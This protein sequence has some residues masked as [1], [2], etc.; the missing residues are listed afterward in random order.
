MIATP[1]RITHTKAPA[2]S[3]AS[4]PPP[5]SSSYPYPSYTSAFNTSTA[6]QGSSSRIRRIWFDS[7]T[8]VSS[9]SYPLE[10]AAAAAAAEAAA[11]AAAED[12]GGKKKPK[13]SKSKPKKGG[14]KGKKKKKGTGGA[15]EED[16][17]PKSG[18]F[19]VDIMPPPPLKQRSDAVGGGGRGDGDDGCNATV[20]RIEFSRLLQQL[21]STG[22][23]LSQY[24]LLRRVRGSVLLTTEDALIIYALICDPVSSCLA[25][26]VGRGDLSQTEADSR[27]T[28]VFVTLCARI[29]DDQVGN[30]ICAPAPCW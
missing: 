28:D 3:G 2:N 22:D 16:V 15:D 30:A 9:L 23:S 4:C 20:T 12:A 19:T 26:E 7:E 18:I 1:Q 11:A 24:T 5:A 6:E 29:A 17:L 27:R 21:N 8:L 13:K 14:K 10:G 25:R